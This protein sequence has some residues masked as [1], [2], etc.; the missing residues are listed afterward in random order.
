MSASTLVALR[1]LLTRKERF[2]T[3]LSFL[4]LFGVTI[5]VFF[6]V[7]V[8]N[9]MNAFQGELAQRWVALNAHITLKELPADF[10]QSASGFK[11]IEEQAEVAWAT[12]IIEGEAIVQSSNRHREEAYGVR[13]RG[14]PLSTPTKMR[15]V[16]F[17]PDLEEFWLTE[18]EMAPIL[19]GEELHFNLGVGAEFNDT[20]NLIY[21][22]GEV[23]PTGDL[24]PRKTE[25][26]V[27]GQLHSGVYQWDAHSVLVPLESAQY[28]FG[29]QA[30]IQVQI[31]LNDINQLASF[32]KKLV[33]HFSDQMVI[34]T[35]AEQNS[36]LFA[37]LRLERIAMFLLLAL[38]GLITSFSIAGLLMMF[39]YSKRRDLAIMRAM[40]LT[41]AGA[42]RIFVKMGLV[43]GGVG[44]LI[45][46][47]GAILLCFY[48]QKSPIALPRSYYL[49][50]LPAQ[51]TWPT[52]IVL[53]G[54]GLLL[55]LCAALYP[56]AL[57][58]RM[59]PLQALRE[60]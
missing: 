31:Y 15:G 57:A 45:G 13:V 44:S 59:Q 43:I 32:K 36:R 37:A 33:T 60:E 5:G 34:E 4:A 52:T 27:A 53:I 16:T 40:G 11:W 14:V 30:A 51:I 23:G 47:I 12:P 39:V 41:A 25:L 38:F 22:L 1:Y 24:I 49:D 46:G 54:L 10:M 6:L 20:V 7:S 9:V 42:R 35:F 18:N 56:V 48:L 58:G 17:Y 3:L 55:A 8:T 21:P 26:R 50:Y 29:D 28:L 2:V 19:I